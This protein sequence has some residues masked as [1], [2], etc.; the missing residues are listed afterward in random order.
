MEHGGVAQWNLIET[1][2]EN[3]SGNQWELLGTELSYCLI[4]S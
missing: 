3:L 4:I 2:A 1:G